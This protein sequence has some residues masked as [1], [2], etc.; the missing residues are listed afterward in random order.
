MDVA[1]TRTPE[2]VRQEIGA[3]REQL[4]RALD[5]LRAETSSVKRTVSRRLKSAVVALVAVVAAVAAVRVLVAR[6]RG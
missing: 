6:I 5:Q 4:V 3:E 1:E 2:L